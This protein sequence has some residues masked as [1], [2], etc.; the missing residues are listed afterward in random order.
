MTDTLKVLGQSNPVSSTLTDAYT[1]GAQKSATVSSVVVCNQSSAAIKFRVSVAIAGA[2][3]TP[4]QYLYYD[5]LVAANDTFAAV[6]G[7]TLAT[8]DVIRVY[9]NSNQVSFNIFGV[10][11][12]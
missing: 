11:V 1:V 10:E 2:A 8:T 12:S 7:V 4:A 3:D 5:V 9:A 6:I